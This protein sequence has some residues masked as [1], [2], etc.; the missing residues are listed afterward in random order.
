M[1]VIQFYTYSKLSMKNFSCST[2]SAVV[3]NCAQN[4]PW[5]ATV[6]LIV[7]PS[8]IGTC[9]ES[10]SHEGSAR[11]ADDSIISIV[12]PSELCTFWFG[13]ISAMTT[14]NWFCV[15]LVSFCSFSFFGL[16]SVIYLYTHKF[17]LIQVHETP[18]VDILIYLIIFYL[19]NRILI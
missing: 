2:E 9:I 16:C 19:D 5:S 6:G 10:N 4:V 17:L 14:R 13:A 1:V 7:I 3:W 11:T 12:H 8:W 15:G 18:S